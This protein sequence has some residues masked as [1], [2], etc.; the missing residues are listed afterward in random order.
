MSEVTE[1][2]LKS[3]KNWYIVCN[4]ANELRAV[5]K[6]LFNMGIGWIMAGLSHHTSIDI[7]FPIALS[8]REYVQQP[9]IRFGWIPFKDGSIADSVDDVEIKF[10]Y[11]ISVATAC[12]DKTRVDL[13]DKIARLEGELLAAREQLAA[14]KQF[15]EKCNA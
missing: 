1:D 2:F 15:E 7:K 3:N 12:V 4:D 14:G 8:P 10:T 13:I 11:D 6:W 9:Y 5:E